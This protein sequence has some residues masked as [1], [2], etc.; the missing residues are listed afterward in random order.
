LIWQR[1]KKLEKT[2][3][4]ILPTIIGVVLRDNN[5]FTKWELD[6][7]L[8]LGYRDNKISI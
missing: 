1:T 7:M 5:G 8:R 6:A 2:M 3:K 4:R